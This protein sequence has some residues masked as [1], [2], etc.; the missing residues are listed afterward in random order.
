MAKSIRYL[1]A[2]LG[3]VAGL[4][5]ALRLVDSA[6][7]AEVLQRDLSG[8]RAL[9]VAGGA[10][11]GGLIGF[12][13]GP[14]ALS[15]AIQF[16]TWLQGR[17]FR[18]PVQDILAGA[19]GLILGLI[20]A[21]LVRPALQL[22]VVGQYLP[23]LATILLGY[24]GWVVVVN[25]RDDLLGL[26]ASLPRV[27]GKEREPAPVRGSYKILDTSAI[28]DG[29]IA[30]I[31]QAG[32]IEGTLVVPQFVLDELRHIAD[33]Q[34]VLKRNRGRRGL[35]I[36]NAMQKD[37]RLPVEIYDRDIGGQDEVD[38]KLVKLATK[39]KAS[40]V[41]NDFNL[42]KVAGLHGVP[43]L[44]LNE[45][46]NAVKPAVLPGEEMVVQIIKDGKEAGQGVAYLDDGTMVVIDG[47]KRYIGEKVSVE[48]T[49]VLQT[50]AGRMIFAKPKGILGDVRAHASNS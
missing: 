36:L 17:L 11:G 14:L 6:L 23:T 45:L 35:D 48:V 47:G 8:F 1:F 42:N 21:Y 25:K 44:N 34:D 12:L 13:A 37:L 4:Y 27:G 30:D 28:I 18:T 41:T 24:L 22:P 29:R 9:A 2:F 26:L 20:I 40:I 31:C 49:S 32:F 10:A 5:S 16:I 39:L 43:V 46:A 38:V 33:S 7:L 50:A 19:I 15:K 3:L